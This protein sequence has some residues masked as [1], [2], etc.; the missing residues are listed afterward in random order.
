MSQGGEYG[1]SNATLPFLMREEEGSPESLGICRVFTD[2]L[3]DSRF[4]GS[5]DTAEPEDRWRSP[6]SVFRPLMDLF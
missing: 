5:G 1:I 6:V 2:G 3:S 4:T